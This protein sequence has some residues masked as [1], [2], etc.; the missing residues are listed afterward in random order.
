MVIRERPVRLAEQRYDVRA[1]LPQ[2][3]DRDDAGD[4]VP[5]IDDDLDAPGERAVALRD[6]IAVA[7]QHG[8]VALAGA[9]PTAG[10]VAIFDQPAQAPGLP[11]G[12][13]LAP[14]YDPEPAELRRVVRAPDPH[15]PAPLEHVRGAAQRPGGQG[16]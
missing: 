4:A 13:R 11:T 15:A 1:D 16:A 3:V 12:H 14:Q 10:G 7:R 5:A 8:V 9:P 6:R 2:R